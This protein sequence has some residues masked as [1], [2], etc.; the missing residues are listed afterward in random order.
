MQEE[1]FRK[2]EAIK[3]IN[4]FLGGL[5]VSDIVIAPVAKVGHVAKITN[6]TYPGLQ[7]TSYVI[8]FLC[9]IVDE[10][11][12]PIESSPLMLSPSTS[13]IVRNHDCDSD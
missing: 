2:S 11:E 7:A 1:I 13:I 10:A 6:E 9:Y 4:S 12:D 5:E 3:S 8:S